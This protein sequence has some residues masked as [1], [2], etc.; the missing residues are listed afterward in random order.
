MKVKFKYGIATS[1]G[2]IDQMVYGNFRNGK[3]CI[4]REYV[5]PKITENNKR[6]GQIGKNISA[7]WN[8][9]SDEYRA[10]FKTYA[11]RFGTAYVPKTKLPPN[12]YA[13][14]MKMIW[15]WVEGEPGLDLE[16]MT[17]EDF[18][19]SN[20]KIINVKSAVDNGFL[21]KVF[22]WEDLTASY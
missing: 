14:F 22:G 16:A 17:Q 19:I 12:A 13:I 4:G 5:Y 7:A 15:L 9:A 21:K 10:D 3:L 6:I 11:Q 20:S 2:T 8:S 18:E 1:S